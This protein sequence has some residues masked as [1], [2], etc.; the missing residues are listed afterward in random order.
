MHG[1]AKSNTLLR[2]EPACPAEVVLEALR[3]RWTIHIL[4]CIADQGAPHFGALKRAIPGVSSKVLTERV[5]HLEQAGI[6]QRHPKPALRP[7]MLYS[8]TSR[9]LELKAVLDNLRE[10]GARWQREDVSKTDSGNQGIAEAA[11]RVRWV[12][13]ATHMTTPRP[14]AWY[15]S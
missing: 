9:G 12:A 15:R 11:S 3:G 7:E 8:L 13:A 10:L 4:K 14:R 6:L 2:R 5:R 1:R